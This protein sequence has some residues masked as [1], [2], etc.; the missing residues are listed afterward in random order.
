MIPPEDVSA[1]PPVPETGAFK[2]EKTPRRL[3]KHRLGVLYLKFMTGCWL[4][5][6]RSRCRRRENRRAGEGRS[7]SAPQ[8]A[9]HD[10]T[11]RDLPCSP[12]HP[13][14]PSQRLLD[15]IQRARRGFE[16]K[17]DQGRRGM[18]WLWPGEWESRASA[19]GS[20]RTGELPAGKTRGTRGRGR[21]VQ[22]RPCGG[23]KCSRLAPRPGE[24]CGTMVE[25][26][27]PL[28]CAICS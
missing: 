21:M 5:L 28:S 23:T 4:F 26:W 1:G 13:P 19:E 16:V 18:I 17:Q 14:P 22:R 11:P 8:P 20:G 25:A 12:S 3:C 6:P 7:T 10:D 2:S 9:G 27:V 24:A 15:A